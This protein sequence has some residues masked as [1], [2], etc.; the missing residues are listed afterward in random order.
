M[1]NFRRWLS[2]LIVT[3]LLAVPVVGFWQFQNIY[4][5][6]R[7]KDYSPPARIAELSDNIKLSDY[8]RRLFYVN[9]PQLS[10]R[11]AFNQ[12][13][14]IYEQTIILGCYI[15][16][17]GIYLF[18]VQDER[19]DGVEEV[20]SAHEMLHAGYDRLSGSERARVDGLTNQAFTSLADERVK[21]VVESYRERDPT[22]V[23][24][25]LHSILA[26]EVRNLPAELEDYY[27]R[28]FTDR[29]AA[30]MYSEKYEAVFTEQQDRIKSM[31][32]QISDLENQLIGD[33]QAIDSLEAEIMRDSERLSRLRTQQNAEEY[34]A[35]VP[36]YNAKVNEYR[37]LVA[38]YNAKVK[39]LN[40][41]V[42]E[43][44]A[45]A[46]EQKKLSDALNSHQES[47]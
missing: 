4:D 25:E 46:V 44:N 10:D 28:Y 11:D 19:L 47:L 2:V 15:T 29:L 39:T 42:E 33:K 26:T 30:V 23:P 45:L 27:K 20:T 32:T 17:D 24:N 31:S 43:H 38:S 16:R 12:K 3:L 34:N 40:R 35:A 6:W 37:G 21:K 18:D 8:G 22:V 1:N 9:R 7:L 13:C 36:G 41:L 14:S 5:W